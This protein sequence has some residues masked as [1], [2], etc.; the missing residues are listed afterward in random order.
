MNM[1]LAKG[2][3]DINPEEKIVKNQVITSLQKIFELYGFMPLET[4]II[5]RYE[6]L[7]AKG[8]KSVNP[9][10]NAVTAKGRHK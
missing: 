3:R 9:F 1:Q 4:P 7:A 2:V 6:T 10:V 5:E 8:F